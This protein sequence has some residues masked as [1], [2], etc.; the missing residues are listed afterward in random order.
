MTRTRARD[1]IALSLISLTV[2]AFF[3][4]LI[5][6]GAW[7]P[8][9][10]GDLVSFLWP[11]YRFAARSLR[12]GTIPLWNPHLYCGAPFAADNQS[13]LFYPVNLVV[14]GLFGQ[15]SYGVMEGLVVLHIWLAAVGTYGLLR[16]LRLRRPAAVLGALAFGLSDLFVTHIGNLNLNATAAWLPFVLWASLRALETMRFPWAAAAG[17]L[18]AVAALAGHA[19]MLLF[20]AFALV[21]LYGCRLIGTVLVGDSRRWA[22]GARTAGL[23]VLTLAVGLGG[24]ALML[25]PAWQMAGHTGRGHLRFDEATRYSLPPRALLG[26]LAPGFYGRGAVNFWGTWDRVEVGYAGVATLVLAGV[27]LWFA[28]S[29]PRAGTSPMRD[30]DGERDGPSASFPAAFFSLLA[31]LAFLFALGRYT[32]LYRLLYRF[33]PTLDQIRAPARFIVLGDLSLAA[34]AAYGLERL[35]SNRGSTRR[36]AVLLGFCLAAAIVALLALGLTRAHSV[37]PPD[38]VPGATRSIL[39]AAALLGISGLAVLLVRWL[40]WTDWLFPVLLAVDLVALGSTIEIERNDPTL[41]FHHPEVVA[42][43]ETDPNLFRIEDDAP[44][45]QPDAALFHGL[46]DIGGIYNPLALAPY[47]AYRWAV[48]ERGS[49]THNFLGVKYVL[50]AKGDPPGDR[51]FQSVYEGREIDVYLNT[52]ALPRALFVSQA[53]VVPDHEAAW[54]AVH[55]PGFDP[56]QT[57]I[58]EEGPGSSRSGAGQ[59]GGARQLSFNRYGLNRVELS[60]TADEDGFLVLSDVYYPGWRATVDGESTSVLRANYTF[61]AVRVPAGAHRVAMAFAPSTWYVGLGVSLITWLA[62]ALMAILLF[63]QRR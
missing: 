53:R 36:F 8:H 7:I 21:L 26:L 27:G 56:R 59:M 31:A 13:G 40:Q 1:L 54:R 49:P 23:G 15:P 34:M 17:A 46:Y 11:M 18:L 32:P 28:V 47:E 45:W 38:R 5:L 37:P 48:G 22:A 20:I 43:L 61:R 51:G 2:L 24:A 52:E 14:F 19:Q 63:V 60:V 12:S 39:F 44:S 3:W 33:V 25:L 30:P 29:R 58:L 16:G 50:A 9:G 6:T 4:P 62:L 57:V 42:F 41:G 10:G 35:A 55:A